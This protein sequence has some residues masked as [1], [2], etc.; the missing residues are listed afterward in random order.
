MTDK[1][2]YEKYSPYFT[3]NKSKISSLQVPELQ[4]LYDWFSS[5]GS[6]SLLTGKWKG[7]ADEF[8][9]EL[10]KQY[11]FA[12]SDTLKPKE[13][14]AETIQRTQ[15]VANQSETG[16][17]ATTN[18]Q[19]AGVTRGKAG[20]LGA[21]GANSASTN[22]TVKGV[23]QNISNASSSQNDWLSQ[24]GYLTNLE[25]ESKNLEKGNLYNVG[26][27]FLGGLGN[28]LKLGSNL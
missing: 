14:S 8:W 1:E 13:Q 27:S 2:L 7:K 16:K 21:A 11:G 6:N 12:E 28:G 10:A 15:D 5:T 25:N 9:D 23:S 18:A 4:E 19:N 17:T 22:D 3:T 26:A 24:Q 20:L